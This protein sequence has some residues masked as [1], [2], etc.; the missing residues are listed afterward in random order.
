MKFSIG[1][2]TTSIYPTGWIS[3]SQTIISGGGDGCIGI[4]TTSIT[5]GVQEI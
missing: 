1:V 3:G 5:S 4:D 2:E